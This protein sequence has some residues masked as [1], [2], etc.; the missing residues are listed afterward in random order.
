MAAAV[1]QG[2]LHH[3]FDTHNMRKKIVAE[4][5]LKFWNNFLIEIGTI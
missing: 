3:I 5:L 4:I 1:F 2:I